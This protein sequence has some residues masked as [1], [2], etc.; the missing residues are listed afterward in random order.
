MTSEASFLSIPLPEEQPITASNQPPLLDILTRPGSLILLRHLAPRLEAAADEALGRLSE[1]LG[2]RLLALELAG[3]YLRWREELSVEEYLASVEFTLARLAANPAAR[4]RFLE[5]T[6]SNPLE[7]MLQL[8]AVFQLSLAQVEWGVGRQMY[9]IAGYCAPGVVI[10]RNLLKAGV[11]SAAKGDEASHERAIEQACERLS[12]LGLAQTS[13]DGLTLHPWLARLARLED[14][15]GE[16]VSR[17]INALKGLSQQ[18]LDSDSLERFSLLRPHIHSVARTAEVCAEV[19]DVAADAGA[20]WNDL[21]DLLRRA[22]EYGAARTI[23]ERALAVCEQKFDAQHPRVALALSNLGNLLRDLCDLPGAQAAFEESLSIR[24]KTLGKQHP[25]TAIAMNDLANLYLQQGEYLKAKTC[26]EQVI[27]VYEQAFGSNTLRA[28][29]AFNSLGMAQQALGNL[30]EARKSYEWALSI[31][32]IY[33][34][35]HHPEVASIVSNLGLVLFDLG[36]LHGARRAFEQALAA[37]E[38]VFGP[39][40]PKVAMMVNNLG[41]VLRLQGELEAARAAHQRALMIDAAAFGPQHPRVGV[42]INNLGNVMQAQGDLPG[43]RSAYERAV[44]IFE[45]ILPPEHPSLVTA[46]SNLQSLFAPKPKKTWR[47]RLAAL[48]GQG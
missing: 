10:P 36:D 13:E 43:A 26:L 24:E 23:F 32:N 46:R 12:D 3:R 35:P 27:A 21:G 6:D 44:A 16:G 4:D 40:H 14:E 30:S 5:W 41:G 47:A 22:G 29:A 45:R 7:A 34:N 2:D 15:R 20:A 8:A 42:D 38:A 25:D 9:L 17:L 28:A 18:M 39:D 11:F 37:D 33:Y 19:E 1:R 48:L 31:N